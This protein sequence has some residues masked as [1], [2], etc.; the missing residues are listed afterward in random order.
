MKIQKKLYVGFQQSRY[1]N[2]ED[3]RV[4]GFMVPYGETKAQKKRMDTVDRWSQKDLPAK[5]YDNN[6]ISGFQIV[7]FASRYST[8]NKLIRVKD[9]RGFELEISVANFLDLVPDITMVKGKIVEDLIWAG[10]TLVCTTSEKY[11]KETKQVEVK[12]HEAG[13]V[14]KTSAGT[15]FYKYM[16]RFYLY[17]ETYKYNVVSASNHHEVARWTPFYYNYGSDRK[18]DWERTPDRYRHRIEVNQNF[19]KT[20]ADVYLVQGAKGDIARIEVRKSQFKDLVQ[21][22]ETDEIPKDLSTKQIPL[23]T[24]IGNCGYSIEGNEMKLFDSRE[25]MN[26]TIPDW[27]HVKEHKGHYGYHHSSY[28]HLE[29]VFFLNNEPV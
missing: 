7:D 23:D 29:K 13:Q 12:R 25:E 27:D 18:Q 5:V 19:H 26:K 3:Q 24:Y 1:R 11:L 21:V 9:P 22:E 15:T 10:S 2:T 14:Y 6:P 17:T 20:L 16:G 8:S 4:L 28:N